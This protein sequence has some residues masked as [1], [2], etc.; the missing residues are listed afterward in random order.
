MIDFY[1][2]LRADKV[3]PRGTTGRH[4][5]DTF[6]Q[7]VASPVEELTDNLSEQILENES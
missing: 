4:C 5:G 1:W 7:M 3:T 2:G 6:A